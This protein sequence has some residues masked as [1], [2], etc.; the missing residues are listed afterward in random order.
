M[1]N[2]SN[3]FVQKLES[4]GVIFHRNNR[5][6]HIVSFYSTI[7]SDEQIR[8]A[9]TIEKSFKPIV[10]KLYDMELSFVHNKIIFDLVVKAI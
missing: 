3:V 10:L 5:L 4:V 8:K 6:I 2:H 1:V 7:L 9:V